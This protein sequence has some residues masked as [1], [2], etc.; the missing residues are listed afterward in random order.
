MKPDHKQ[1]HGAASDRQPRRASKGLTKEKEMPMNSRV[2]VRRPLLVQ[3]ATEAGSPNPQHLPQDH[4]GRERMV[5]SQER[6]ALACPRRC[7]RR[8][9]PDRLRRSGNRGGG[10]T[11]CSGTGLRA[12]QRRHRPDLRLRGGHP[13]V[14]LG[15]GAGFHW[16]RRARSSGCGHHP[17]PGARWHTNG[18][19]YHARQPLLPVLRPWQ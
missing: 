10:T 17:P 4:S 12:G 8:K 2:D 1:Q 13:G 19:G 3:H 16:L 5:H 6:L 11:K 7:H 15:A 9:R 14:R 18:A